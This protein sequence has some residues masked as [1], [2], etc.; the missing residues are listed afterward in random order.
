MQNDGAK[1]MAKTL[2][3]VIRDKMGDGASDFYIDNINEDANDKTFTLEFVAYNYMWI[4]IGYSRGSVLASVVEDNRQLIIDGFDGW[5]E[6][7]DLDEWIPKLAEEIKLR[8]P[9]KYLK[10]K[11][12]L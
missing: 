9:D 12:W 5:W 7:L 11:G 4:G 8:I 3:G 2:V 10:A 6:K 1:N